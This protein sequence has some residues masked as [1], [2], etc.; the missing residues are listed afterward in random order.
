M[1]AVSATLLSIIA[2][3]VLLGAD[4]KED[5]DAIKREKAKLRGT[6][7]AVYAEQEGTPGPEEQI[8]KFGLVFRD[9]KVVLKGGESDWEA[10]YTVDPAA[11]PATLD[12]VPTK[13]DE[14]D[15]KGSGNG[16]RL[17]IY[18]LNGDELKICGVDGPSDDR[19]RE[20]VSKRKD[21]TILIVFKRA[22]K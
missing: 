22:A 20:F 10:T 14:D 7:K 5:A 21:H 3:G 9:D 1:R 2:T 12:L 8:K 16:K 6:W 17:W 15:L 11:N 19:P 4:V 13:P 18:Q